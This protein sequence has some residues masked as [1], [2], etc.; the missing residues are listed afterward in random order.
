MEHI[1]QASDIAH[2]MQEWEI[3]HQWNEHLFHE[4]YPSFLDGRAEEYASEEW[5]MEDL[6]YFDN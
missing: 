1:I 6:S 3:N 5:Y 4:I 2:T